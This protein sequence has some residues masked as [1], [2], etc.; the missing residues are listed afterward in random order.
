MPRRGHHQAGSNSAPRHLGQGTATSPET[1]FVSFFM[2][3]HFR[4]RHQRAF[5]SSNAF[6]RDAWSG[7]QRTSVN[8]LPR[9]LSPRVLRELAFPRR[10][11]RGF[12]CPRLT[13]CPERMPRTRFFFGLSR[14]QSRSLLWSERRLVEGRR[15]KANPTREREL[16]AE[17][18]DQE[19]PLIGCLFDD[20]AGGF[21][22]AVASAG[23]DSD[24]H[25]CGARLSG[26]ESSG[27]LKAVG[28]EA[29]A[30]IKNARFIGKDR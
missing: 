29:T 14:D 21:S 10:K 5:T 17:A 3:P 28:S 20:F 25:R 7:P 27:E 1:G 24:Q 22:G 15:R 30:E 12:A 8:H 13:R 19:G 4:H 9:Q 18:L 16:H 11:G 2:C 23:F 26:L 6:S